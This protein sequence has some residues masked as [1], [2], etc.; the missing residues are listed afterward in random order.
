MSHVG[1]GE[2]GA[3]AF[4]LHELSQKTLQWLRRASR[5]LALATSFANA[6]ANFDFELLL[7]VMT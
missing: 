3:N 6:L 4:S 7:S 2:T 1:S 5:P